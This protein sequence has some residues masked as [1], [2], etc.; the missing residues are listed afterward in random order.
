MKLQF[1]WTR[2]EPCNAQ[3][4]VF[5][6]WDAFNKWCDKNELHDMKAVG[7]MPDGGAQHWGCYISNDKQPFMY[8]MVLP[9]DFQ[10]ETVYHEA[11]H[12]AMTMWEQAG[13]ELDM[14]RNQEVVTYTQT[15]IVQQIHALYET[16][17]EYENGDKN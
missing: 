10:T 16:K 17:E 15:H 12:C 14:T 1:M 4:T 13:A 5:F 2:I 7:D 3:I 6:N 8:V 9:E 11:L